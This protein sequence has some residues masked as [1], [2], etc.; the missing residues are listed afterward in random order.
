MLNPLDAPHHMR[1]HEESQFREGV[2]IDDAT[3]TEQQ[4]KS[5]VDCGLQEVSSI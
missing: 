5:F 4:H 3:T 1:A 2:V